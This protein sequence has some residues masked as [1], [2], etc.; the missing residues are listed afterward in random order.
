VHS[1]QCYYEKKMRRRIRR[2]KREKCQG[3]VGG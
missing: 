1:H 3:L 2:K